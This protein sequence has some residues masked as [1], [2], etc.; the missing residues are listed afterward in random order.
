LGTGQQRNAFTSAKRRRDASTCE[1][2]VAKRDPPAIIIA[3]ANEARKFSMIGRCGFSAMS[4]MTANLLSLS[5]DDGNNN[6]EIF[7]E[8]NGR[9][10]ITSAVSRLDRATNET[11]RIAERAALG[12]L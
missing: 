1:L 3:E 4:P 7:I 8:E 12:R 5:L 9:L 6:K 10:K 2:N 11:A